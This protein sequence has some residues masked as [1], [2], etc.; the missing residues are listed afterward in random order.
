MVGRK[1]HHSQEEIRVAMLR[2]N[3]LRAMGTASRREVAEQAGLEVEDIDSLLASSTVGDLY[4]VSRL[5]AALG[6]A[7]W[8]RLNL[9]GDAR[10]SSTPA[11]LDDGR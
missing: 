10:E 2:D 1:N 3:L 7:L 11:E 9:G 8:P 6:A 4:V 5:E